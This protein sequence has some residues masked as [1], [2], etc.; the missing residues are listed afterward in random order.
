MMDLFA[1]HNERHQRLEALATTLLSMSSLIGLHGWYQS[2]DDL[3][4]AADDA[5]DAARILLGERI[6]APEA[7]HA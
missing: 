5:E 4:E 2:S 7:D 6:Q 1:E 3:K